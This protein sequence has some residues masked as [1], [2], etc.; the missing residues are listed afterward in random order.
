MTSVYYYFLAICQYVMST[1]VELNDVFSL[2]HHCKVTNIVCF[3]KHFLKKF[4]LN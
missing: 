3:Y 1:F 4:F 2:S